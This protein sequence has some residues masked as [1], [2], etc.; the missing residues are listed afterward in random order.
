MSPFGCPDNKFTPI[1]LLQSSSHTFLSYFF[2]LVASKGLFLQKER[3]VEV[4]V[5]MSYSRS[6]QPLS[7]RG[8]MANRQRHV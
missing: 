4:E 2:V 6:Q 8:R 3:E 7:R 1:Q 5:E